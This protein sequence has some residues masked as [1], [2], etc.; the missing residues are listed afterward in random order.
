MKFTE[1]L[2]PPLSTN[3]ITIIGK[4]CPSGISL[5]NKGE[6]CEFVRLMGHLCIYCWL[7]FL[8]LEAP[9]IYASYHF[10]IKICDS[11]QKLNCKMDARKQRMK[12]EKE[13]N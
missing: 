8:L 4:D 5:E 1:L 7:L 6:G 2:C 9:C 12:K 11:P 10:L 13:N 3:G